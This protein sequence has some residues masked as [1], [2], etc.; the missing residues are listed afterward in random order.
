MLSDTR[1]RIAAVIA[2]LE[3]VRPVPHMYMVRHDPDLAVAF[4]RGV[5]ITAER[6][7]GICTDGELRCRVWEAHGWE[8][9]ARGP[10][11]QMQRAGLTDEAIVDELIAI[12]IEVW[13]RVASGESP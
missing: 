12:E 4:L 3:S 2:L 10:V 6:L 7:L 1:E 9:G 5:V 13:R 11:P 8:R